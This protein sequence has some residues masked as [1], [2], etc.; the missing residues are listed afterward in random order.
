MLLPESGTGGNAAAN[1][2][3][4]FKAII[5]KFPVQHARLLQYLLSFLS[6]VIQQCNENKVL[7]YFVPLSSGVNHE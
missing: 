2:I 4:K 5:R 6:S 3:P 1:R 7:V